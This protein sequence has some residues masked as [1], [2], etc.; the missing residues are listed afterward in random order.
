MSQKHTK[1]TKAPNL[2]SPLPEYD[3]DQFL[4]LTNQL[5]LY[6][7]DVD[8]VNRQVKGHLDMLLTLQW[9]GDN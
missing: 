1:V 7:N 6:F 3:R 2:A 5:R 8:G 4:Q 9:L